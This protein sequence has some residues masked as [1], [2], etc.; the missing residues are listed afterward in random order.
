MKTT[1]IAL[2]ASVAFVSAALAGE[3]PK[4]DPT[5]QATP[6]AAAPTSSAS[7]DKASTDDQAT[8]KTGV[9]SATVSTATPDDKGKEA[10]KAGAKDQSDPTPKK[11]AEHHVKYSGGEGSTWKTGRDAYGF[12]GSFGGCQYRGHAG[13]NGYHIDKSC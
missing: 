4:S 8:V 6:A 11:L 5:M 2:A 9:T 10:D 7:G 3:L 1:L 12:A 13:P